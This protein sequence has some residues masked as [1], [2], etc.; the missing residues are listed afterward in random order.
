MI[1]LLDAGNTRVKWATL[2]R[3]GVVP[4]GA[5]AYEGA[6]LEA[7]LEA[8]IGGLEAPRRVVLCDVAAAAASRRLVR[9]LR[10]RWEAPVAGVH[11][12]RRGAGVVSAYAE[13]GRLGSDRW[14]TLIAAHAD[15]AGVAS[16]IVDA[17]TALTVDL[18]GADGR[19]HGGLIVPGLGLARATLAE[20]TGRIGLAVDD[21][22]PRPLLPAQGTRDAVLTGTLYQLVALLDRVA[23]DFATAHGGPVRG[24][25][26]GGDAARL[27]PLLGS[28]Y[29]HR[30]HLVLEGLA[31][32]AR[33]RSNLRPLTA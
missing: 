18:L 26:T 32:L 28:D 20:R 4:G 30:P 5:V 16:C 23:A 2:G 9:W 1:L 12:G 10:R 11:P 7:N 25:L 14:A 22:E 21:G 27:R 33:A 29:A 13:P 15:K 8:A 24:L 17:G 3:G 31:V 19:H 6:G